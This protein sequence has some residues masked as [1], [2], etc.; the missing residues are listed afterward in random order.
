MTPQEMMESIRQGSSGPGAIESSDMDRLKYIVF[1]IGDKPY[2][3]PAED[4]QEIMLDMT[5]HYLPFLPDFIRGL[6]NR[7]GEP[8]TLVDLQSLFTRHPLE[9]RVF[10][11]L[12]P[13]ISKMA[14][15]ISAVQDI[16]PA[17]PEHLRRLSAMT[18]THESFLSGILDHKGEEVHL[19]SLDA[20]LDAVREALHA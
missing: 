3:L 17:L 13:H 11:I 4:V 6:V 2:A 14:F 16:A 19:L 10:L 20:V 18:G 1:R 8:Y 15:N 9:G 5:I 12:K 7:L